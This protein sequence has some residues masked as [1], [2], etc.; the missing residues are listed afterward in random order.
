MVSAERE[1]EWEREREREREG[2]GV[3]T[4]CF[5]TVLQEGY[6]ILCKEDNKD[7]IAQYDNC[8]IQYRTISSLYPRTKRMDR[9]ENTLPT[10][11]NSAPSAHLCLYVD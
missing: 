4:S 10:Y 2:P 8:A 9:N 5:C 3:K 7:N 11:C 6:F 1:R